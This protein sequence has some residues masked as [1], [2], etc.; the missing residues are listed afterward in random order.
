M[1][2]YQD[3]YHWFEFDYIFGIS[4]HWYHYCEHDEVVNILLR[5][6]KK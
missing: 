1:K 5:M 4:C 6:D 2:V 3:R